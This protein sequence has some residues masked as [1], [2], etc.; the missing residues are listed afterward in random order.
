M[1][2]SCYNYAES[3]RGA[4]PPADGHALE[5]T[6]NFGTQYAGEEYKGHGSSYYVGMDSMGDQ[7]RRGGGYARQWRHGTGKGGTR[8]GSGEAGILWMEHQIKQ[9]EKVDP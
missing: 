9:M 4:L 2:R 6:S 8:S 7:Q 5:T 3:M 1:L